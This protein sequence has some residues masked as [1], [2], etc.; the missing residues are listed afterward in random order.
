MLIGVYQSL[1]ASAVELGIADPVRAEAFK[2][3]MTEAGEDGRYY[4]LTPILIAAWT[5]LA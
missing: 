3:D 1:F 5:R 2:A 4:C